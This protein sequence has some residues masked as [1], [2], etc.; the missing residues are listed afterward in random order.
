MMFGEYDSFA[1][2]QC[3]H[4]NLE[5]VFPS[6][7]KYENRFYFTGQINPKTSSTVSAQL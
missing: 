1:F 6:C 7:Q 5:D 4:E 2:N 3:N